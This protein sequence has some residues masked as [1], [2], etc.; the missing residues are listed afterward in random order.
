[1]TDTPRSLDL[2]AW[3]ARAAS[4]AGDTVTD[5]A[6][7]DL[8]AEILRSHDEVHARRW[9]AAVPQRFHRV[10]LLDFGGSPWIGEACAWASDSTVRRNAVI[11]GPVGVGKTHLAAA[12]CRPAVEAGLDVRLVPMHRFIRGI[13]PGGD[14]GYFDRLADMDRLILDDVGAERQTDWTQTSFDALVAYRW[15]EERPT[16]YTT[17]MDADTLRAHVGEHT[18]SRM[19]AGALAIALGGPDRRRT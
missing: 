9:H 12:M 19:C 16:I 10:S 13:R 5:P 14:D 2:S 1:M 6:D 18:Y 11:V 15:E 7:I 8:S 3:A 17:N 4:H